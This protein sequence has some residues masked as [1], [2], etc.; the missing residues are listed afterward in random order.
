[1]TLRK[2]K[3]DNGLFIEAFS[4]THEIDALSGKEDDFPESSLFRVYRA[5]IQ[6]LSAGPQGLR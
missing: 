1:M 4:E 2:V 3:K 6:E 5:G